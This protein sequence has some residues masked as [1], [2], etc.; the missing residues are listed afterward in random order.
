MVA[1]VYVTLRKSIPTKEEDPAKGMSDDDIRDEI[2]HM[3]AGTSLEII[4]VV[5]RVSNLPEAQDE[6]K[7]KKKP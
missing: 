4:K 5:K 6:E 2:E 7:D 1:K 3:D